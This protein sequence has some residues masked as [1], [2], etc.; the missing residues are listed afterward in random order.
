MH[1]AKTI[2]LG[3]F[4][5]V[6]CRLI[7]QN[8]TS[9]FDNSVV[10]ELRFYFTE[11]NFWD[12]LSHNWE[13]YHDDSGVDI[14]YLHATLLLDGVQLDSVGFR[15]KGLSSHWASSKLK[16]PFK[17]DLN[18]F[19]TG[20]NFEGI[21]KFSLHNGACDPGMMR[22]FV[23]YNV[24]RTAGVRA[25]R[26]SFCRL[27][28]NDE[29]W[30]LYGIIEQIDKTFTDANF[31]N[32]G[33]LI[34]NIGWTEL[35]W[36]GDSIEIYQK[37]F[38]LKTNEDTYDW[39][40]FLNFMDVVNN[41]SDDEFPAAIQ[42][43]FDV[44]LYLHVLA[45]DIMTNNWDSYIDNERNFYLYDEPSGK[46][47]HWIPW[48]YNLSMGG[49]FPTGGNPFPPFDSSCYIQ[50]NFSHLQFDST[51]MLTNHTLPAADYVEWDFGFG[52]T[53]NLFN[54]T[55][56][57]EA[58]GERTICLTAYRNEGNQVC[59]NRRCQKFDLS[60][61]PGQCETI[62]NG[63]C[64]YP[65]TDPIFQKVAQQDSYCCEDEW[66]AVCALQYYEILQ[67][68]PNYGSIGSP[69][70]EYDLNFPLLLDDT[71]KILV[72]RLLQVSAFR[73]RY[74]DICCLMMAKNFNKDRLF[75]MIDGQRDL[76]R[77]HIYEDPNYVFTKDY[78]EYDLGN[79]TGGG[80]GAQIP[81][82]KWILDQRFDQVAENLASTGHDCSKAF[83]P[84]GWQGVVI[85]EIMAS[86]S[87]E[88]GI[89]DP[90]GEYDDW[91]ELFNNTNQAIDLKNFYLTDTTGFRLKW[92]FPFGSVI[93]PNGYLIVWA[94]KDEDQQGIHANFKLSAQGEELMLSH[95]DGTV[96]DVVSYFQQE[97]NTSYARVPNGTGNLI[98]QYPTFNGNNNITD[99]A[100]L[101]DNKGSFH[102]YPNPARDFI[103][104]E[105]FNEATE[106]ATI[107]LCNLLG[108]VI[109]L[110]TKISSTKQRFS[111][112]GLTSGVYFIESRQEKS[113]TVKRVLI[114][115]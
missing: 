65:A 10:H 12:S 84:I 11:E 45:A 15:Q 53:S 26:V 95:E 59:Q 51:F 8:G 54:P 47:F 6:S 100:E 63:S 88:S 5:T 52:Q 98:P 16:K 79:G 76:I 38:Q 57:F 113:M 77:P 92:T 93:A 37:D 34:K 21:K 2:F 72:H 103:I 102:V 62:L 109:E 56:T 94:D 32:D 106:P 112:A 111:T 19:V 39:G 97:E 25:P 46:Q 7:G 108:E 86:N 60:F 40:S 105:L 30:G 78:F 81:S 23:G 55:A 90:D 48:D 33:T 29:Y 17:V 101:N 50:A 68:P 89:A 24:L 41:S 74:L 91:I 96:I 49:D 80:G 35:D 18:E 110:G 82:L 115:H 9:L 75:P 58:Q 64:P 71:S 1:T 36:V 107:T 70:V 73:K 22:D 14:P 20:Q 13:E 114:Q 66:D 3:I 28:L 69:G 83:S 61:N 99:V 4:L 42:K 87:D 31:D 27:Y 67:N 43:V 104:V 44:D 85:N